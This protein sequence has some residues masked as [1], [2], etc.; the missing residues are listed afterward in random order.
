[1]QHARLFS[2]TSVRPLIARSHRSRKFTVL[3]LESSADDSC[4]AVVTSDRT[5]LSNVVINQQSFIEEY[6]GIHPFIALH[7]HQR[8]MPGAVQRALR[9]ANLSVNDVDGI[10]FTRGPGIPGCLSVCGNAART[11]AAAL[12]KPLVGVHH[13]QAHALTPLLTSPPSELPQFPFLTLLVS[14]GHTILLL[15]SSRTSFRILATTLDESIGNAYDKVA[16]MLKIP[17][18][19][20]AP[21]AALERY[22][23]SE[24]PPA[25][26]GEEQDVP[27]IPMPIPMPGKLAFSY[28]A[29]HSAVERFLTAGGGELDERTRVRLARSFQRAAVG[30]LEEKLVLAMRKLANQGVKVKSLVVSGG[31][32]SNSFLRERL[33]ACLDA[34]SPEERISLVFPPPSLCTDNAVM[35]AWAAMDRFLAG[36]TDPY[37]IESRPKWSLEELEGPERPVDVSSQ[38]SLRSL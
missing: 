26:D 21:G 29:P 4:A 23:A 35:I 2:P 20:R 22:C 18:N 24:L 3:A 14:G 7:A 30:Q 33:R 10:A 16:K 1:M 36:D 5:V 13:M 8:N 25:A 34:E 9:E 6:G 28:S 27:D 37:S 11:L 38:D 17:L 12:N 32:A 15:A 19:G 31:V